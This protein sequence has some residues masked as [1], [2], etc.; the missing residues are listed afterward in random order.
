MFLPEEQSSFS[1]GRQSLHASEILLNDAQRISRLLFLLVQLFS[2][3]QSV[4][5]EST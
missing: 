2:V 4:G 5:M 1:L 3:V